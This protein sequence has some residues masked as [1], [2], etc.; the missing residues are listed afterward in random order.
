MKT[1]LKKYLL[2]LILLF[3]GDIGGF[4]YWKFIVFLDGTCPIKSNP[5][6]MTMYGSVFGFLLGSIITDFIIKKPSKDKKNEV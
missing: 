3:A 6:L 4:L 2:S 5:M 1:F